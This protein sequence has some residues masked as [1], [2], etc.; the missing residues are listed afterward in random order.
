M[1]WFLALIVLSG[2]RVEVYEGDDKEKVVYDLP[3]KPTSMSRGLR[4]ISTH[5]I[6]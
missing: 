6:S 1:T 2:W 3:L 4:T 5:G